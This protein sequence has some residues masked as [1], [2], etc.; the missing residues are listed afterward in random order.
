MIKIVSPHLPNMPWEDKPQNYNGPIWR[1]SQNPIV[2]RNPI[3]NVSRVFNSALIPYKGEYIGVFRGET[4]TGVPYLYLGHSKDG[5]EIIFKEEPLE[6]IDENN[7]L[8]HFEYA[9]D[10]RLIEI[11]N[12]F[13]IVFCTSVRGPTVGLIKT[14]DFETF[15]MLEHPFLPFNRN[16]VLFPRKINGEY[17]M[18]SRP[19]D[20]A[21][22][23]FGD[24]FLSYSPDLKYWGKHRHVMEAGYEWW[25]NTKIGGGANPIETSEGWLIFFHGVTTTCNGF[26]YSIGGAL[27]DLEKPEK[28]LYRSAN[29]LLSPE[30]DYEVSGFTPNVVFP[31]SA[32]VD[33]KTGRIAIY[34][35]GADTNTSLAFTTVEES[36]KFIKKYAR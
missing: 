36:I 31:C 20:S 13:Y 14:L 3:K 28:V 35:G 22:T 34:Y 26:V 12:V 8:V 33:S 24:I 4:K 15:V 19:S 30:E 5:I 2:K 23:N 29:Y 27:L 6:V 10:P 11:E 1:Y 21:H 9:Y 7:E 17:V 32:L 25:C 18:L 16:G